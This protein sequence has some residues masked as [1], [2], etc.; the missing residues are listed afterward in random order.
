[1]VRW[2]ATAVLLKV[3]KTVKVKLWSVRALVKVGGPTLL[4]PPPHVPTV[5]V[6]FIP[7]RPRAPVGS[8]SS[9]AAK[10][11]A[12]KKS[13]ILGTVLLLQAPDDV[14]DVGAKAAATESSATPTP[15]SGLLASHWDG[16]C[17]G[18]G[19]DAKT[20]R[21]SGSAAPT[22]PRHGAVGV[23]ADLGGSRVTATP[24]SPLVHPL[25]TAV[26][27]AAET[28]DNHG[29]AI[30]TSVMVLADRV[31]DGPSCNTPAATSGYC[32][33]S[34]TQGVGVSADNVVSRTVETP[35][36]PP[37]APA[38]CTSNA[39]APLASF[40]SFLLHHGPGRANDD[41]TMTHS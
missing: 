17:G 31:D 2:P 23:A 36:P 26:G 10:P 41:V 39:P 33:I 9:I 12:S 32:T 16:R 40:V 38:S 20:G 6:P 22:P 30:P 37:Q 24:T 1:V 8:V 19:A 25:L 3:T 27:I 13:P 4:P 21:T 35:T 28:V 14:V 5:I 7:I 11:V 34:S 15:P 29:S 18:V